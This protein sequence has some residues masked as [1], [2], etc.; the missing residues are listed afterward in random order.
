MGLH[1]HD[2]VYRESRKDRSWLQALIYELWVIRYRFD[3]T[4]GLYV[5]T[6]GEKLVC[7]L[8][9]VALVASISYLTCRICQL[10]LFLSARG[11]AQLVDLDGLPPVW[12]I[13][14]KVFVAPQQ[15]LRM[16]LR[17]AETALQTV[18]GI[19]SA[20]AVAGGPVGR[21]ASLSASP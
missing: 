16:P 12:S 4:M 7:Y 20:L 3:V 9:L 10:V 21:N 11:A 1:S 8:F 19:E 15:T 14:D 5:M 17:A 6:S 2:E 18:E 13:M